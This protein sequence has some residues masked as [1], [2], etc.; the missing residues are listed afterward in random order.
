MKQPPPI[1]RFYSQQLEKSYILM[2]DCDN[3]VQYCQCTQEKERSIERAVY[4]LTANRWYVN[5]RL[6]A[7]GNFVR[8]QFAVLSFPMI[9]F[10]FESTLY[11]NICRIYPSM[12]SPYQ[13]LNNTDSF[14]LPDQGKKMAANARLIL[15][16]LTR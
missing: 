8:N 5:G 12:E 4:C 7:I 9:S 15:N 11:V 10:Y 6:I 2:N 3:K 1:V 13:T 14:E 16:F